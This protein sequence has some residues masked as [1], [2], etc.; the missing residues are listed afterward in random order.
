M[1]LVRRQ[2]YALIFLRIFLA[3]TMVIHGIA[4]IYAGGV[5]PFGEFL[6]AQGFPSGFYLAWAITVFEIIGGI[7]LAAGFFVPVLAVIFAL[8]LLAGIILVHAKDGWFVVGLGRNGVEYSILLIVSFLVTA[9]AHKEP[10]KRR[11]F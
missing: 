9:F 6:T 8:H 1:D 4:R 5:A 11:R 2:N 10:E 7:A 3:A